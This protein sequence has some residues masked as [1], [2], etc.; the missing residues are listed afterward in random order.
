MNKSDKESLIVGGAMLG[1]IGTIAVH[2]SYTRYRK[3]KMV[4]NLVSRIRTDQVRKS[5]IDKVHDTVISPTSKETP[6][7]TKRLLSGGNFP[8]VPTANQNTKPKNYISLASKNLDPR[9][10]NVSGG[11]KAV[12]TPV[13]VIKKTANIIKPTM[14]PTASNMSGKGASNSNLNKFSRF[15]GKAFTALKATSVVGA[16][17]YAASSTPVGDAT[18]DGKKYKYDIPKLPNLKR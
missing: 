2:D 17:S 14:T 11:V 16:I 3:K 10:H 8:N 12:Q 7:L 5:V 4:K 18:M 1:T 15:M 13:K 6:K 9:V